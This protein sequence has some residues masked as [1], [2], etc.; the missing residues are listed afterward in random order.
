[1][2]LYTLATM[3]DLNVTF[4]GLALK[5]PLIV[6]FYDEFPSVKAL[7]D[8]AGAGA[9]AALLPPLNETRLNWSPDEGEL[10]ENNRSGSAIR[11]SE[12]I[13]RRINQDAYMERIA[14]LAHSAT[15]PIIAALQCERRNQWINTAKTMKEAGAA[16]IELYPLPERTW[17]TSRSNRVEK[18]IIRIGYGVATRLDIPITVRLIA[19]P[20]GMQAVVQSLSDGEVK[21]I[22]LA[23]S[24][25]LTTIDP[26]TG[27]T[28]TTATDG[29]RGDA[30]FMTSLAAL[31][32]LY[33]RVTPHLAPRIPPD[34]ITA[35]TESILAGATLATVPV[36]AGS[37]KRINAIVGEHL[38]TLHAWMRR[39]GYESLFDF[40]GILSDSRRSSSLENPVANDA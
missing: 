36:S 18:E 13:R 20:Y 25:F 4:A 15:V 10:L 8:V 1:M 26:D 17:R 29:R 34:R 38:A 22:V 27:T 2:R 14:D 9:G 40:R 23:G 32:V 16:A 24:E 33:R 30:S 31:Q 6:E 19:A 39:K 7:G 37:E 21:G 12:A 35:L 11:E 28:D 5:S 3:A